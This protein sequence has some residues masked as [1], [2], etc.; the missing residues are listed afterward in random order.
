MHNCWCMC[1]LVKRKSDR[2][3]TNLECAHAGSGDPPRVAVLDR[4]FKGVLHH[5]P[6]SKRA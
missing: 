6:V 3:G 2:R 4:G 5:S 1:A